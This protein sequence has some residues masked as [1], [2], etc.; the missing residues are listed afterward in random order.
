MKT[1]QQ[2]RNDMTVFRVKVIVGAIQVSRHNAS[3]VSTMLAV[4]TLAELYARN[5]C[6]CI[7]FIRGLKWTAEQSRLQNRLLS[8]LRV[9]ATRSEEQKLMYTCFMG[10]IDNVAFDHQ[11]FIDEVRRIGAVCVDA[12]DFGRCQVDLIHRILIKPALDLLLI[13]QIQLFSVCDK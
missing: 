7:G 12:T 10:C 1:A 4:V 6:Y 8:E 13:Q 9:D 11:I 3:V 5:F 2:S